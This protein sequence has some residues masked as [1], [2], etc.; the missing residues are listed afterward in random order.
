MVC[1]K[2][3]ITKIGKLTIITINFFRATILLGYLPQELLG[4]SVYEFYHQ[5]DISV[6]SDIHRKGNTIL[7]YLVLF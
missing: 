7:Q 1:Y 2:H 5:D 6:M 4:T 3:L